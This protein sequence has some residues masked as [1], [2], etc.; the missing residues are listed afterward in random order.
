MILAAPIV[1]RI[2]VLVACVLVGFV[3]STVTASTGH[4]G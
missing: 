4:G 2:V 1:L 3:A